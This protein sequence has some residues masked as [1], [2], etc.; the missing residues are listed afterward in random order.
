MVDY[1]NVK[2]SG[3]DLEAMLALVNGKRQVPVLVEDGRVT[4]GFGGT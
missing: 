3:A 2:K 1:R 4:V